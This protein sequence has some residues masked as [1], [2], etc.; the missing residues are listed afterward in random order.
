M[1]MMI[2][3]EQVTPLL[4]ITSRKAR[5]GIPQKFSFIMMGLITAMMAPSLRDA[6]ESCHLFIELL[7]PGLV[8][9]C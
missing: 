3:P 4:P 9:Y 7:S 6:W 1:T 2:F 5:N 8:D